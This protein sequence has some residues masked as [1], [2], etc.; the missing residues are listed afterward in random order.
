[1]MESVS[2]KLRISVW[3]QVKVYVLF[4]AREQVIQ[5]IVRVQDRQVKNVVQD[6]IGCM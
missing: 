2:Y 1:M 6:E 3:N 5:C 4:R